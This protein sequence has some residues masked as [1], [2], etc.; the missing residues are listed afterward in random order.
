MAP[1]ICQIQ[2]YQVQRSC[3]QVSMAEA[4]LPMDII[5]NFGFWKVYKDSKSCLF[6]LCVECS[7]LRKNYI[8][9]PLYQIGWEAWNNINKFLL[10]YW[11]TPLPWDPLPPKMR[12]R[13]P[14]GRL[15]LASLALSDAAVT[16]REGRVEAAPWVHHL[17]GG[18]RSTLQLF[19]KL[20]L[21]PCPEVLCCALCVSPELSAVPLIMVWFSLPNRHGRQA[22]P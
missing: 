13:R 19:L 14:Q 5:Y 1:Q 2:M 3:R 10:V 12:Y 18:S 8:N 15:V 4:L 9:Y 20:W 16:G 11:D 22:G 7:K 6:P 17:N 21:L